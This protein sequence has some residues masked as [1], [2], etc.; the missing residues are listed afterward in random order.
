MQKNEFCIDK[1]LGFT[2]FQLFSIEKL[3]FFFK[4]KKNQQYIGFWPNQNSQFAPGAA[5][6]LA[7]ASMCV[8][9]PLFFLTAARTLSSKLLLGKKVTKKGTSQK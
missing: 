9:F 6:H 5:A 8:F 1:T 7:A 2:L 4:K 3:W